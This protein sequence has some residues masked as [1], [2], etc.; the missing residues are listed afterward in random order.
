MKFW[1]SDDALREMSALQDRMVSSNMLTFLQVR[2]C[3]PLSIDDFRERNFPGKQHLTLVE[4]E[5]DTNLTRDVRK[6]LRHA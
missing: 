4:T 3:G 6:Q 2:Q 5:F 1:H